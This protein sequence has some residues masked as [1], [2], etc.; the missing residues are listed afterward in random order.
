M[1]CVHLALKTAPLFAVVMAQM[2]RA[3]S[4]GNIFGCREHSVWFCPKY[5]LKRGERDG[6]A[7]THSGGRGTG[8][9]SIEG[10][11]AKRLNAL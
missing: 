8:G 2:C 5:S 6:R 1:S 7:L 4:F 3:K 11:E 9:N 10:E